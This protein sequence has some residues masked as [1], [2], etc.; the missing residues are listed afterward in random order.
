M[1]FSGSCGAQGRDLHWF[2]GRTRDW[3]A[4]ARCCRLCQLTTHPPLTLGRVCQS[5][6]KQPKHLTST[7]RPKRFQFLLCLLV[8]SGLP[9]DRIIY[10]I[11]WIHQPSWCGDCNACNAC[12]T[13]SDSTTLQRVSSL[14]SSLL[15]NG[16]PDQPQL[17]ARDLVARCPGIRES[18]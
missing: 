12:L 14:P 1:N 4:E 13:H 10:S 5:G 15:Y 7:E 18:A 8:F 17:S 11:C 6:L 9:L 2:W 3:A 16:R